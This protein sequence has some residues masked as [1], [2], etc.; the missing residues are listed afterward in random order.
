M[1]KVVNRMRELPLGKEMASDEG[2]D[3]DNDQH[4]T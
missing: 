1:R 3:S 2:L 4:I